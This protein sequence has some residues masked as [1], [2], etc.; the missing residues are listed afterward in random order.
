MSDESFAFAASLKKYRKMH[1][2][3]QKDLAGFLNVSESTVKKW[4]TGALFPRL[5][6]AVELSEKLELT[7]DELALNISPHN[8][9]TYREKGLSPTSIEILRHR[10]EVITFYLQRIIEP[11]LQADGI[12]CDIIHMASV[13]KDYTGEDMP[14]SARYECS[15]I[16]WSLIEIFSR[17]IDS[18]VENLSNAEDDSSLLNSLLLNPHALSTYKDFGSI[19]RS[20]DEEEKK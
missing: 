9:N 14:D 19:L 4:E 6:E 3:T 20:K 13:E 17:L 1:G 10:D 12:V 11:L 8:V 15:G 2:M 5:D 7:V 16:K 18:A